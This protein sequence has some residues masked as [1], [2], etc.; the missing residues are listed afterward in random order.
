MRVNTKVIIGVVGAA[1]MLSVS[2]MGLVGTR[3]TT[4]TP[5]PDHM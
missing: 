4:T 5:R 3:H 1:L 2:A